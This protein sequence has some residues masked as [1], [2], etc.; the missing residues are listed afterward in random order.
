MLRNFVKSR[1]SDFWRVSG[2]VSDFAVDLASGPLRS[3]VGFAP[4]RLQQALSVIGSSAVGLMKTS[5]RVG[6]DLQRR[7]VD[8]AFDAAELQPVTGALAEA[9]S[10]VYAPR[11]KWSQHQPALDYL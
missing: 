3:V 2:D 4:S 11:S 7:T 9:G 6:E 10:P 8:L 1:I 5:L